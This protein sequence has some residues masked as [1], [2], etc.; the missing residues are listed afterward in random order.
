METQEWQALAFGGQKCFL[1]YVVQT[2]IQH[3]CKRHTLSVVVCRGEQF[4]FFFIKKKSKKFL[5]RN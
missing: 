3:A 2:H 1:I 5:S 4:H